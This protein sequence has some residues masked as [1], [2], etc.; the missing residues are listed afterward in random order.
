[1]TYLL[2][3][4]LVIGHF[5]NDPSAVHLLDQL[6]P[7][8]IAISVITYMEAYQG[9]LR[10]DDY[11]EAEQRFSDLLS[12]IPVLPVSMPVARRCARLREAL[13]GQGVQAGRVRGRAL[14][15]VIAATAVE[16]GLILA[17]RN[18]DDFKNI[19]DLQIY[20]ADK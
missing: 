5:N 19:P 17:T 18:V 1:M 7:D 9:V 13:L 2:D 20:Q 12:I 3:S 6:A 15:L 16:F 4:N 10:S 8:G 14:D 11:D